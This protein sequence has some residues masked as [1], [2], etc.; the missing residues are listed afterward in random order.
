MLAARQYL[1][2]FACRSCPAQA[3]PAIK[4]GKSMEFKIISTN[5]A[6]ATNYNVKVNTGIRLV[7]RSS[8]VSH[9]NPHGKWLAT[10]NIEMDLFLKFSAVGHFSIPIYIRSVQNNPSYPLLH[11]HSNDT[12]QYPCWHPGNGMHRSHF[13]P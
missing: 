4:M 12:L 11:T 6:N 2:L 7:L 3:A 10:K 8:L 13:S 5:S 9:G 1:A